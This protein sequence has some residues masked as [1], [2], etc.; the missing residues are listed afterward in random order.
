MVESIHKRIRRLRKQRGLSLEAFAGQL[1][2]KYQSAQQWE[3]E[4]GTAPTRKRLEA[5]ARALGVTV[6]ELVTGAT[7][8]VEAKEPPAEYGDPRA[9]RLSAL[10]YWLT[11]QEKDELMRDVEAKAAGNRAI[12]R[13]LGPK[14]NPVSDEKVAHAFKKITKRQGK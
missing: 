10:F 13:E 9:K 7:A 4:N 8:P 1:G 3:R 11:E 6:P 14:L 5:V 12:A 2:I